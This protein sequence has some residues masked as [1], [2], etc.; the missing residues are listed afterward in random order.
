[1]ST[2]GFIGPVKDMAALRA[3]ASEI[4]GPR[5]AE[6]LEAQRRERCH[7]ERVF[8]VETPMGPMSLIYRDAPN[9]GYRMAH[10]AAS[11]NAFDKFYMQSVQKVAGVDFTKLPPGPPPHLVFEWTNGRAGKNCTMIG[12]PVPDASKFWKLCR[13][14]TQRSAEHSESR[15]RHGITL[16]RAFYLHDAKMAVVYMEGDDPQK[17][18]ES[19]TSSTAAYDV[20]FAEQI[21]N[22]HGI[23]FRAHKPPKAELL[24]SYDG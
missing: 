12:A 18:L 13:E 16:E 1:M 11:S 24:V 14:M 20:W 6:Y 8:L 2:I 19:N 3:L 7:K 5:K 23:D 4:N 9:A 22:V 15:E 17:A 21:S 10:I